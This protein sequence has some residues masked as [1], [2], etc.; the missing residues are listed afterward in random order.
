MVQTSVSQY[1]KCRKTGTLPELANQQ[2][3]GRRIGTR[4]RKGSLKQPCTHHLESEAI[5]EEEYQTFT[6]IYT[7]LRV[8]ISLLAFL[9]SCDT[10]V[11]RLN[12][13]AET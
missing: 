5:E 13:S 6:F 2:V 8:R 9:S 7:K 11:Q 1:L 10:R 3:Q 12:Y 4:G